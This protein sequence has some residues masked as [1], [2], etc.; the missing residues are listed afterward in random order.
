[1]EN[2]TQNK[3][4][5]PTP[6][7][8]DQASTPTRST[9][10]IHINPLPLAIH[11]KKKP[12]TPNL[13]NDQIMTKEG[14]IDDETPQ[15]SRPSDTTEAYNNAGEDYISLASSASQSEYCIAIGISQDFW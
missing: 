9:T 1:M 7:P 3:N 5:P 8:S 10:R 14:K 13:S 4:P 6:P 12:R 15:T 11:N 2:H